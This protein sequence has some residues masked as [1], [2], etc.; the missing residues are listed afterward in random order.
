MVAEV[1]AGVSAFKAMFD[2][3]KGLKDIDNA[4][5]RNAAVIELQEKILA[6]QSTQTD[7]IQ[8]IGELEKEVAGLKSWEAEKQRYELKRYD[9]GTLFYLLKE[10]EA[11]GEP[12]HHLCAKCYKNSKPS[13]VQQ[14]GNM[15]AR[16]PSHFCPECKTQFHVYR[17]AASL[18][19]NL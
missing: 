13:I 6:A 16:E 8:R 9:P 18:A 10:A 12:I 1:Y 15:M 4:T 14:T 17:N 11:R 5:H 3:A 7:L 19:A 2:I